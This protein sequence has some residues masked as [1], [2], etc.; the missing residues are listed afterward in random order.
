MFGFLGYIGP[1]GLED[2][3]FGFRDLYSS[4]VIVASG[5]PFD[6]RDFLLRRVFICVWFIILVEWIFI[7]GF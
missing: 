4:L 7:F 1:V 5:L 2:E 6:V 3:K